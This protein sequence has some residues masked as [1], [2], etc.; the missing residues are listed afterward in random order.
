MRDFPL[1]CK[2]FFKFLLKSFLISSIFC[3]LPVLNFALQDMESPCFFCRAD[4]IFETRDSVHT[5]NGID[6]I[7][8]H[9]RSV[10]HTFAE[11]NSVKPEK[12]FKKKDVAKFCGSCHDDELKIFLK[13]Q[14]NK[15]V[16]NSP[17][18]STCHKSHR[19]ENNKET[20]E[21]CVTCH[22]NNSK[23]NESTPP[24]QQKQTKNI[25][26]AFS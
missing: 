8:C 7:S 23:E 2:R 1:T 3:I 20:K 15:E 17:T 11:D 5:K 21:V 22:G 12:I 26:S 9:G 4:L 16:E 18:C 19:F 10:D 25:S 24:D 14:H 13:G 6:C